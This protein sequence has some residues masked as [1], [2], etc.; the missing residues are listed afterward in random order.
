MEGETSHL[1]VRLFFLLGNVFWV[2]GVRG[3]IF[4]KVT[5]AA[6]DGGGG[7]FF[8][9]MVERM[10]LLWGGFFLCFGRFLLVHGGQNAAIV[11]RFLL[12]FWEVFSGGWWREC[13]SCG[14]FFFLCFG[15]FLLVDGGENA[16]LVGGWGFFLCFGRFLVVDGGQNA[17]R[18]VV[19]FSLFFFVGPVRVDVTTARTL[20]GEGGGGGGGG[21]AR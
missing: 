5:V 7:G 10:Q 8:W 16:A 15:R 21:S 13:N 19:G 2:G 20:T 6:V 12:V 18:V 1:G 11:V 9:W 17:V 3:A 4:I 14:F